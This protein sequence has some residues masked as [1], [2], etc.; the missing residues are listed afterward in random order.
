[1]TSLSSALSSA[2]S[3]LLVTS[4]QSAVLSRNVTRA[5]DQDYSRR[6]VGLT[7]A[8]DGTAQ[9]GAYTRSADK[10][11]QDRVLRTSSQYVDAGITY[12]AL[13]TLSSIIG[14]PEDNTSVAAGLFALQ[15]SMRE[16]Q[17]N[18]SSSTYASVAI[19]DAR[20]LA[21]RLNSSAEE[22]TRIRSEAHDGV[23]A[24]V[25]H[26]N[27]LLSDL[28]VVDKSIRSGKVG[29]E[30]YLD[31]LDKRDAIIRQ[32]SEEVGLRI[33]NKSD[34]GVSLYTDSGITLFDVVPRPVELRADGPLVPGALGP[35]VFI[36]G[37]QVSGGNSIMTILNGKL[38]AQLAVRD[39]T[40][41][42]YEA[43]MDETARSLITLFAESDQSAVPI[44]PPA[45]GLFT[46][47]GSPT[48]PTA[49]THIPGLAGHIAI[50]ALFDEA[51]GGNPALLRDGGSNGIAYNYNFA[52]VSGF[53]QRLSDLA[54]SFD[55]PVSFDAAAKLGSQFS[56]KAFAEA[57]ASRL[58]SERTGASDVLDETKA[59]HQRWMEA[60]L[61]AT[62]VNLDEEMASL[63]SLEKSYQ[64]SAKV[65]TTIDQMF[66]VLVG[67]V[68]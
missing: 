55:A 27:S 45:T 50:N 10:G 21:M 48:V 61:S 25:D 4:G 2:L 8:Q 33:V 9:L 65:M 63:L 7:V 14:D 43:Q 38:S 12:E 62:G 31:G 5:S 24:S 26:I 23:R 36:D 54:Q 1:M 58:A 56:I 59:S 41:L 32:L 44:L 51:L 40:T 30:S 39:E 46:Y 28:E 35:A 18:P 42:K 68:R 11:L 47:G 67:I 19:A 22:I 16:Y 57:S 52:G 34:G 3:G 20:S 49:A 29:T 37:V 15:Q 66:A 17:N 53:Q 64:A 13:S 6:D 60:S